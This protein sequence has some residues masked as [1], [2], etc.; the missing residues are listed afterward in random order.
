M[1]IQILL[2]SAIILIAPLLTLWSTA[3]GPAG[4]FKENLKG[5][6]EKSM[7]MVKDNLLWNSP[8]ELTWLGDANNP[9]FAWTNGTYN[10][11]WQ[12]NR[13]G[14]WDIYYLRLTPYGFKLVN[15]T[16]ITKYSGN[17]T[18]P[19]IAVKEDYIFV[20]WQRF[21]GRHWAIYFS[22]LEYSNKNISI[23]VAPK[24]IENSPYN[25]TN[26][27]IAVDSHGFLHVTWQEYRNKWEIM[28]DKLNA[29]GNPVFSPV[30]VSAV[31]N[32]FRP[33]ITITPNNNVEIVWI[34]KQTTPGYGLMYRGLNC[35][36]LEMTPIRRISIVSPTT[37]VRIAYNQNIQVVFS[38][39][40]ENKSSEI[41]YTELND[42]GITL[43]DDSNL[44]SI[45]GINSS[46]P[47]MVSL[48]KRMFVAWQ[49]SPG[50]IKF[51]E[52]N[53]QGKKIEKSIVI[54]DGNS[55]LPKIAVGDN[56]LAITWI[57]RMENHTYL[58]MRSAIIPDLI[59]ST[60]ETTEN[61]NL[62]NV[63]VSIYDSPD[64]PLSPIYTLYVDNNPLENGT[65]EINGTAIANFTLH[66]NGGP[67]NV[68]FIINA[69]NRIY[70]RNLTNN[71]IS[72]TIFVK[73]PKFEIEMQTDY[74]MNATGGNISM[75]IINTGNVN[76]SYNI[77]VVNAS[78]MLRLGDT[79]RKISLSPGSS[80]LV[81]F[82]VKPVEDIPV[83]NYTILFNV[84]SSYG[85]WNLSTVNI[86]ILPKIV[87]T[88]NYM[89]VI[90]TAPGKKAEI[91]IEI[92]NLGNCNTTYS[93]KFCTSTTWPVESTNETLNLSIGGTGKFL[94]YVSVP[95]NAP[96]F[97]KDI[98]FGE[99]ITTPE[100]FTE[101][102]SI[103]VITNVQ[104]GAEINILAEEFIN[105]VYNISLMITNTGNI[106]D[107][108][109][110]AIS[111][112]LANY[113]IIS[114]NSELIP[115]GD[116]AN[117]TLIINMPHNA[118]AGAHSIIFG[119]SIGNQSIT[120]RRITVT[121]P[122]IY[123][124]SALAKSTSTK[125]LNIELEI[126]N[127]GNAIETVFI[128]PK[129][130]KNV[131]WLIKID[132]KEFKNETY[133]VLHPGARKTI[134]ISTLSKLNDGT[135]K[136]SIL[137]SS[138]FGENMTLHID[139]QIGPKNTSILGFIMDNLLYIAIAA[140]VAVIAVVYFLRRE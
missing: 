65:I 48:R 28:Y 9:S 119:V 116:H 94:I 64:I 97:T 62:V 45:D 63:S 73:I 82:T 42:T 113:S 122:P 103:V 12:D 59:A 69:D 92:K 80:R 53:M 124:F 58:M 29:E 67:H 51:A 138:P 112:D 41:I 77:N 104:H 57:K 86:H 61:R 137:L 83:G 6:M 90:Y 121:A 70:E 71:E 52:F 11:V 56:S 60:I 10:L 32:S 134:T 16:R 115:M 38:D 136:V 21:I 79:N 75:E 30:V 68:R 15:D 76:D 111:G 66:L 81:N 85:D 129:M 24:P 101:N 96:A 47:S 105:G 1:R 22:K 13:N 33:S 43:V 109:S 128:K 50:F 18:N 125:A 27:Q 131:T 99:V 49:D 89:P 14:N 74:Y 5:Q 44:T 7:Q 100:N 123:G 46:A 17:D 78:P 108:F 34:T 72:T 19:A 102:F 98:I 39:T 37:E 106:A 130:D 25:A 26:P 20:A 4:Y 3:G 135:Y 133:V 140:I 126:N 36:S 132:G 55:S 54:S 120:Y 2:V 35:C 117:I 110:F 84:S 118:S 87:F 93:L 114:K 91:S 8:V 127:T 88:I 23:E 107:L 31:G 139:V 40:R 95:P